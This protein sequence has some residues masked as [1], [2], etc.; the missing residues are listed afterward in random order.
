VRKP[1]R[2]KFELTIVDAAPPGDAEAI[3][4]LRALLKRM[5]RS[6]GFRCTRVVAAKAPTEQAP[7]P[8]IDN[9]R[10]SG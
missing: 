7:P 10:Q 4:R 3:L 9:E 5:L 8:N 2:E 1:A 6:W